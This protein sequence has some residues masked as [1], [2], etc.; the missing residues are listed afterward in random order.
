MTPDI[1]S[2]WIEVINTHHKNVL[3]CSLYREWKTLTNTQSVSTSNS[4]QH[5]IDRIEIINHQIA[6]ATTE[7]K[8]KL[9]MGDINLC[10][11]DWNVPDYSWKNLADLW[12]SIIK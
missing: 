6:R 12:R 1:P 11:S 8:P 4:L 3:I 2:I 5:Q 10:M 9:I 7:N